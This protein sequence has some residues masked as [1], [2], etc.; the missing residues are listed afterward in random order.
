MRSAK[1]E[2]TYDD[3]IRRYFV[4]IE[5]FHPLKVV[6]KDK[7]DLLLDGARKIEIQYFDEG[8]LVK[9]M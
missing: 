5:H 1:L 2:I 7:I 4:E 6:V 8:M 9:K 3:D